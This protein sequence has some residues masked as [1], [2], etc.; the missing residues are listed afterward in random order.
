MIILHIAHIHNNSFSG[1]CVIVPQ[2]IRAQKK[3]ST[4]GFMN[5]SNERIDSLDSQLIYQEEFDINNLPAP[6]NKPD[7]VIFHET[8]RKEYLKIGKNLKKN[9]V[10]YIIVPHGSLSSVAQKNKKIKKAVANKLFFNRFIKDAE[11]LQ[12]LSENEKNR[13]K[14]HP[15]KFLG[16]NGVEI[17]SNKKTH[18]SENEKKIVYIGRLEFYCKGIDLMLGAIKIKKDLLLENN[19]KFYIYGPD[20]KNRRK[21]IK[22]LIEK[23]NVQDIVTLLDA[24][25]GDEK[26]QILINTDIFIQTSRSEGMPL[27]ILE[28]LSYGVPCLITEGTNIGDYVKRYN[29]GWVAKTDSVS[30]ADKLIEAVLDSNVW[31]EKSKNA[32]KLATEEFSWENV[33]KIAIDYYINIKK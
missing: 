30:I 9:G 12:C 10:P 6:Y 20:Y 21:V 14:F 13:T 24:V 25:S 16:T 26:E 27:G 1:V 4:V 15:N 7:I 28:A 5:T 29:A 18:F 31:T 23:N 11:A 33:A 22:R 17:P 8:Y 2:H 19:C 3:Y 32:I